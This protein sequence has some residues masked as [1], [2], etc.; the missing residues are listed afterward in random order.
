MKNIFTAV[1]G[2]VV[3]AAVLILQGCAALPDDVYV[4]SF[5]KTESGCYVGKKPDFFSKITWSGECVN[6]LAT[7]KGT[8][9]A[10]KKDKPTEIAERYDGLMSRGMFDGKGTFT[11]GN[12]VEYGT[13]VDAYHNSSNRGK[14]YGRLFVDRKLSRDGEFDSNNR[15]ENGR[16]FFNTG[17]Y[18]QGIFDVNAKNFNYGTGEGIKSG[19]RYPPAEF[20]SD[21]A[22]ASDTKLTAIQKQELDDE[23]LYGKTLIEKP[24]IGGYFQG[25][26]YNSIA[27]LE[28]AQAEYAIAKAERDRIEAAEAA[29]RARVQAIADAERARVQA[30]ADA[31]RYRIQQ[32]ENAKQARYNQLRQPC[33]DARNEASSLTDPRLEELKAEAIGLSGAALVVA[34]SRKNKYDTNNLQR[35]LNANVEN[36]RRQEAIFAQNKERARARAETICQRAEQAVNNQRNQDA[37]AEANERLALEK[38]RKVAEYKKA[39]E[40]RARTNTDDPKVFGGRGG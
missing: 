24:P 31:E 25:K 37:Q 15:L 17:H 33:T 21:C 39:S 3:V 22:D 5:A 14:F 29:E 40:A 26:V 27:A 4:K 30:I 36:T 23:C 20:K 8:F 11:Y 13:F 9:I 10:Y 6:G 7:G 12:R 32:I 16:V 1:R 38:N 19:K 18:V 2:W 35:E 34:L 28:K